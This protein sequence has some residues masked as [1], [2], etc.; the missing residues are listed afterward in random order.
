LL[1]A[2][3]ADKRLRNARELDARDNAKLSGRDFLLQRLDASA[4]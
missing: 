1:L 4:R 3:G 2:R